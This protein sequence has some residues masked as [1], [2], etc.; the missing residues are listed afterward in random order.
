MTAPNNLIHLTRDR[1]YRFI[2]RDPILDEITR[3]ISKSGLS[4]PEIC[5]L[6]HKASHSI[7]RPSITTLSNWQNGTTRRPQNFTIT[8]VAHALGYRRAFVPLRKIEK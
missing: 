7:Y 3:L 8:W 6:V 4:L 1:G 2:D 5:D